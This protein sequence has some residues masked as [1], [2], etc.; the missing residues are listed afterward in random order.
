MDN[1]KINSSMPLINVLHGRAC[2]TGQQ[3]RHSSRCGRLHAG[4]R[5]ACLQMPLCTDIFAVAR[6]RRARQM[7]EL[8]QHGGSACMLYPFDVPKCYC[9]LPVCRRGHCCHARRTCSTGR[10]NLSDSG[11]PAVAVLQWPQPQQQCPKYFDP[12]SKKFRKV[13]ITSQ[14]AMF[15]SPQQKPST[16]LPPSGPTPPPTNSVGSTTAILRADKCSDATH[17]GGEMM[18]AHGRSHA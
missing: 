12:S 1:L 7:F 8:N 18:Y 3:C 2:P 9:Y 13:V 15:R 4:I 17:T 5:Q 10:P 6:R 16:M 11:S 14:G